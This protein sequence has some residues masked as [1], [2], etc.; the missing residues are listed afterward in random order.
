MDSL[1]LFWKR[2][3]IIVEAFINF[4]EV[5][6]MSKTVGVL[7]LVWLAFSLNNAEADTTG[8]YSIQGRIIPYEGPDSTESAGEDVATQRANLSTARVTITGQN[9]DSNGND[10][11]VELA[12]GNFDEGRVDLQ[13]KVDQPTSVEVSVDIGVEEP[14]RLHAVLAPDTELSFVINE[15]PAPYPSRIEWYGAS[16]VAID[17]ARK[18]S[19]FGD[20]SSI[21]LDMEG[22][23]VEVSSWEYDANGERLILD[24]GRVVLDKGKFVIEA[25]VDEPKFANV[26]VL[27]MAAR[28]HTQ[29]HVVVEPGAEIEVVARSTWIGDLHPVSGTGK[30][31]KLLESWRQNKEYVATKNEYREA[32]LASQTSSAETNAE[33]PVAESDESAKASEPPRHLELKR[34]LN[35]FRYDFLEDVASNASDPIDSLLALELGAYWGKE[36]ALAIYDRL[37][38]ALDKDMVVRRVTT[39]RNN[40]ARHLAS[41]GTDRS[42]AIGK[43]VPNFTLPDRIGADRSLS[44]I[45]DANTFVFVDFWASWC[46]PC[47]ES[48]PALKDIYATYRRNGLEIVSVSVDDDEESWIERS[49]ELELPW[50]NLGELKGFKGEI[51]TSYGVTF[52]PK[53]Y[54]VDADGVIV[55]KNLT[56]E[57][58]K[59]F[60]AQ[61]LGDSAA[62]AP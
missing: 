50:I 20:L 34:K 24:F 30:H 46:S 51:A 37:A 3:V 49:E 43:S 35:R 26:V 36:E 32:Y 39:D 28:E 8:S 60:L 33:A 4:L 62:P 1:G 58:L 61:E 54:L 41:V 53:G 22:A 12:A 44:D 57:Q 15:Y 10:A 38:K 19:I 6:R 56:P 14:L 5:Y 48:I 42:L 40:H 52:I 59:D 23:I 45:L 29:F 55:Q 9:S 31:Y 17:P 11:R 13:G 21:D 2:A 27:V 47:I 18:F 16:R 25:E 7:S